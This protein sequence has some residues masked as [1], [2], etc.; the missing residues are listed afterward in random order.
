MRTKQLVCAMVLSFFMLQNSQASE[1]SL[2]DV[3]DDYRQNGIS[4]TQKIFE[5]FFT[6]ESYWQAALQNKDTDFGYYESIRY[7]FVSDKSIPTLWLYKIE[8][9]HLTQ[10]HQVNS[11]VG[12]GDGAKKLEGDKITPI[13]VYEFVD[14]FTKLDQ[15]YGPMAFATNYPNLYDRILKRSGSGIWIHGMPLNG[16][17]KEQNTKGCIAVEN[18]FIKQFDKDIDYSKTLLISYDKEMPKVE[19]ADLAKILAMLFTWRDAWISN[20][21]NQYLSFYAPSFKRSDGMGLKSFSSYKT[22][23]FKKNEKKTIKI[24]QI[25]L[26]PYPNQEGKKLFRLSFMQKYNAFKG[27]MQTYSSRDYKELYVEIKDNK[28]MIIIEK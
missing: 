25:N 13:G 12:I 24:S 10:L 21:I 1:M 20:D 6:K 9:S 26:S 15:Y 8:N 23:V 11:I 16:D 7:L 5:S 28:A 17:R 14:K 22:R 3:V 4:S 18:N 2:Y 19:K 27:N